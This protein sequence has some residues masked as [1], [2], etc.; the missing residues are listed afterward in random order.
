MGPC[1][2]V[3]DWLNSKYNKEKWEFIQMSQGVR[4]GSVD[5]NLLRGDIRGKGVLAKLT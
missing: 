5:R 2:R 3:R 4:W 1:G